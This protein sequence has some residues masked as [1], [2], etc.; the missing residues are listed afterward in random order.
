MEE[1]EVQ[2]DNRKAYFLPAKH[3]KYAKLFLGENGKD[4]GD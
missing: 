2:K 4:L 1:N 3:A